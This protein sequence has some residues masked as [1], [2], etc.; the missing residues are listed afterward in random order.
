MRFFKKTNI[1]FIGKRFIFYS[2]SAALILAG[3]ISLSV[4]GL[5]LGID[6]LGGT[7]IVVH[8]SN[9]V[10]IGDV[11][12]AMAA[13]ALGE[14]EIKYFGNQ[15]DVLVRTRKQGPG[16]S[17]SLEIQGALRQR[18]GQDELSIIKEDKI[19]PKIGGELRLDALYAIVTSLI[20]VLIYLGFRFQFMYG[21]GAVIALFHD[22]FVTLGLLSI[23]NGLTPYLNL[24]ISQTVV[25]AFLTL[26]GF[27]SNDTV[28]I[29]D[30]IRENRK[31]YRTEGLIQ[32]F[33]RSINETLSRTIITAG[34]I[35]TVLLMLFL[36]GGEVNRGFAF[37]LLIGT[38]TGT[39]STIYVASALVIDWTLF[40][41]R[42]KN[43]QSKKIAPAS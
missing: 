25:A 12:S 17:V 40:K 14:S 2:I 19:G 1:D 4:K 42:R 15:N 20:V 21:A 43:A 11:R 8:F 10:A 37:A 16:S 27:S 23:V 31:L 39:Y 36:F 24:E 33:N 5:D 28:V 30:R 6:F 13:I 26:V 34:T 3:I 22:V 35:F 18:F 32:I 9:P 7:E 41:E 29:F 38:I